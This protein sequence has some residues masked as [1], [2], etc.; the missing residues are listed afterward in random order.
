M[1]S[2]LLSLWVYTMFELPIYYGGS[3]NQNGVLRLAG[4]ALLVLDILRTFLALDLNKHM[5]N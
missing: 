3:S 4:F 2:L 1:V 5:T